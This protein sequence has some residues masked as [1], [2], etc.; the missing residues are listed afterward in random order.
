MPSNA[1]TVWLNVLKG[2]E[3][4]MPVF[5]DFRTTLLALTGLQPATY[6]GINTQ[7]QGEHSVYDLNFLE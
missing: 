3:G 2:A 4:Q 5:T 7:S 6:E 1:N